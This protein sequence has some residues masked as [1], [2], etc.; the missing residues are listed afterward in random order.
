MNA[1]NAMQLF[2]NIKNA[3]GRPPLVLREDTPRYLEETSSDVSDI[4]LP[5][6]PRS[7]LGCFEDSRVPH[8]IVEGSVACKP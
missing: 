3:G 7:C 6:Q 1:R 8:S 2:P 4:F 5:C